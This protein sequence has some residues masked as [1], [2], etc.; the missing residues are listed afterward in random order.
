MPR[1][2][3][4]SSHSNEW[5]QR[6]NRGATGVEYGQCLLEVKGAFVSPSGVH[7][8][9]E[10]GMK[11]RIADNYQA[12]CRSEWGRRREAL[13]WAQLELQSS[14]TGMRALDLG[15]GPGGMS[16]RLAVA[17][18]QVTAVDQSEE[19]LNLA[20]EL[21]QVNGVS[22]PEIVCNDATSF[23]AGCPARAFDLI[24]CHNVIEYLGD[25]GRCLRLV[26]RC[27]DDRG[28]LSLVSLNPYGEVLRRAGVGLWNEALQHSVRGR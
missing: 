24:L 1:L 20:R 25:A 18:C 8:S 11:E 23:L 17:G 12:Y 15:C 22:G 28:T 27:L 3:R 5:E 13:I 2:C 6:Y 4:V 19:M 21:I 14:V 26:R 7:D 16:L 10:Y 9:S